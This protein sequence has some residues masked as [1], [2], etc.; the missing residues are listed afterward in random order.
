MNPSKTLI[1]FLHGSGGNGPE[2]SAFFQNVPIEE[3]AMN[4]YHNVAK[5]MSIDLLCPTARS[6]P[7]TAMMNQNS[8][9]W[10][11]RSAD[12]MRKGIE[13]VED[14]A[15]ADES[16]QQILSIVEEKATRYESIF[17]GGFSMGGCL[18]LHLLRTEAA[19]KLPSNV[20]GLFSMGSFLVE[21][22]AVLGEWTEGPDGAPR[23]SLSGTVYRPI[24]LSTRAPLPLTP[25]IMTL[26][27]TYLTLPLPCQIFLCL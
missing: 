20:K 15:G 9:V 6:R 18:A 3:F 16:I 17:V 4:S 2:L 21:R 5:E 13:D 22:S 19:G 11:D 25:L 8:N 12:F 14:L 24:L 7:Y 27:L 1:V 10:F 23:S 26:I